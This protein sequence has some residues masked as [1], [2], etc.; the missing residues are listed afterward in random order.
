MLSLQLEMQI[1]YFEFSSTPL[2]CSDVHVANSQF[3][4]FGHNEVSLP[5]LFECVI[6]NQ[7]FFD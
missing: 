3:V 7:F 4:G 5:H 6:D 2:A 1:A